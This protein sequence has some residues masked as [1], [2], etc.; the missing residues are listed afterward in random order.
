MIL[1]AA[2]HESASLIGRSG[3]SAFRLSTTTAISMSRAGSCFFSED[4]LLE[5]YSISQCSFNEQ[6][7]PLFPS[8]MSS[9]I[10]RSNILIVWIPMGCDAKLDIVPRCISVIANAEIS[11]AISID[12]NQRP[13]VTE[14][15]K[16]ETVSAKNAEKKAGIVAG[17]TSSSRPFAQ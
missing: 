17:S 12:S 10:L 5:S 3:S 1:F 6:T 15:L 8:A 14:E 9:S 4:T 11:R 2:V 13:L 16:E 7:A